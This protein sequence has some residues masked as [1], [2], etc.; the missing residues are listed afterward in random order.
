MTKP[1]PK[2][3]FTPPEYDGTS[4]SIIKGFRDNHAAMQLQDQKAKEAGTLVGRYIEE[5]I[6]DGAAYYVIIRENKKSVRVRRVTGVGD[7][8][9]VPYWG[10]EATIDKVFALQNI[11]WRDTC[12]KAM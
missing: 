6:A 12:A 2:Y 10:D 4:E 7:D 1:K 11:G 9:T 8:W 3:A 5:G